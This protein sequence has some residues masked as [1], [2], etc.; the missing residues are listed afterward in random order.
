MSVNGKT[1]M[2]LITHCRACTLQVDGFLFLDNETIHCATR[3]P[4][5]RIPHAQP[6][7]NPCTLPPS[8]SLHAARRL[9]AGAAPAQHRVRAALWTRGGAPAGERRRCAALSHSASPLTPCC[10][11]RAS[12]P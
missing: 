8:A 7:P 10:K 4:Q 6:L 9:S 11:R 1:S 2:P 5:T 3:I 12:L